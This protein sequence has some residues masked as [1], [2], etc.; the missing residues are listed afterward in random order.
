M[1]GCKYFG[2][3]NAEGQQNGRGFIFQRRNPYLAEILVG[4]F[5]NGKSVVGT[6]I[7]EIRF[8]G[9]GYRITVLITECLIDEYGKRRSRTTKYKSKGGVDVYDDEE[10]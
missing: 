2:E 8:K 7:F 10:Y 6:T 9:A 5:E 3:V 4:R 1:N